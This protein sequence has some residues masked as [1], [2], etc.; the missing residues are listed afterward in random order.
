M[1]GIVEEKR[2]RD[3]EPGLTGSGK[4]VAFERAR[5]QPCRKASTKKNGL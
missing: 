1:S 2:N 3:Y 4:S 5:L